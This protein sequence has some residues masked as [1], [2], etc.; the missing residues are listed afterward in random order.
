MV[1]IEKQ[2]NR[3]S[4]DAPTYVERPRLEV[5]RIYDRKKPEL[6]WKTIIIETVY[7]NIKDGSDYKNLITLY[8]RFAGEKKDP[9]LRFRAYHKIIKNTENV[10]VEET[11][12][13]TGGEL[14]IWN[15]DYKGHRLGR[16]LFN[17]VIVW[18]KQWPDADVNSIMLGPTDASEDNIERRNKLYKKSGIVFE[19]NNDHEHRT[20]RSYVMKAS[21]L[22]V[23]SSWKKENGGNILVQSIDDY[24]KELLNENEVLKRKIENQEWEIFSL[25]SKISIFEDNP[26]KTAI[27]KLFN[28][29]YYK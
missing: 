2:D 9:D 29:R 13:L 24:I 17:E 22:I 23:L 3:V 18:A 20:G 15:H 7:E 5:L 1:A 8:F 19:P 27:K 25:K 10:I 6:Y 12:S 21:K 16:W 26:I 11:T 4:K 28:I 14:G